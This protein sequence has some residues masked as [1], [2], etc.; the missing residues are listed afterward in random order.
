MQVDLIQ[1]ATQEGS[2]IVEISE[3]SD[4]RGLAVNRSLPF[5]HYELSAKT[6]ASGHDGKVEAFI[7]VVRDYLEAAKQNDQAAAE[8]LAKG[9]PA[10]AHFQDTVEFLKTSAVPAIKI[11]ALD[12]KLNPTVAIV[13]TE[14]VA[15]THNPLASEGHLLF[16]LDHGTIVDID[17]ESPDGLDGE[18]KSFA[19][20]YPDS[21]TVSTP[22]PKSD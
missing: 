16:T 20:K 11:I 5:G 13:A 1:T 10:R 14:R 12:R 8:A 21:I 3:T 4:A 6:V 9:N 7:K 17:F 19:K 15:L 22:N 2:K 18:L